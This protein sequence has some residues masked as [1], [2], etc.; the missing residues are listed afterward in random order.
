[1]QLSV[2]IETNIDEFNYC[3]PNPNNNGEGRVSLSPIPYVELTESQMN[4]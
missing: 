3:N 1:M 4:W 2:F